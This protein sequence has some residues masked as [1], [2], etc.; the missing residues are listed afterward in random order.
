MRTMPIDTISAAM[1]AAS[2][3]AV[4]NGGILQ[5]ACIVSDMCSSWIGASRAQTSSTILADIERVNTTT[6]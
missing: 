4:L 1:E 2:S 3:K 5:T 6:L